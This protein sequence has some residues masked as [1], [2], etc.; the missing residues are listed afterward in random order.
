[1]AVLAPAYVPRRPTETVLYSL[2]REH[3]FRAPALDKPSRRP[4]VPLARKIFVRSGSRT[5]RLEADGHV[6]RGRDRLGAVLP[7]VVPNVAHVL[8]RVAGERDAERPDG[9]KTDDFEAVDA[10]PA[11]GRLEGFK[12]RGLTAWIV[13]AASPMAATS[14]GGRVRAGVLGCIDE[15]DAGVAK[16]GARLGI[17]DR[18][19]RRRDGRRG[20]ARQVGAPRC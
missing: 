8:G 13:G 5:E 11:V 4:S 9:R 7:V 3:P 20:R 18:H 10:C 12:I 2:V 1:V 16:R 14:T 19:H 6:L 15:E 17:D